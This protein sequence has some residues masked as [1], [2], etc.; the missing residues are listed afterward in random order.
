M[1]RQR[2]YDPSTGLDV[3][4]VLAVR[5]PMLALS[6]AQPSAESWRETARMVSEKQTAF[7]LGMIG[8]QEALF[9]AWLAGTWDSARIATEM[10]A[11]AEAPALKTLRGNVRRLSRSRRA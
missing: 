11:A 2:L 6:F 8:A 9:R 1:A 3:A 7:A 5:L 4:L 10:A